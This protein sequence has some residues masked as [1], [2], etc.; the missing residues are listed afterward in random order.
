MR[1]AVAAALV[2]TMG[3]FRDKRGRLAHSSFA[4]CLYFLFS[5]IFVVCCWWTFDVVWIAGFFCCWIEVY[6]SFSFL[7]EI[8]MAG[9]F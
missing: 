2:G 6:L 4:I 5:F 7:L 9:K 3:F 1:E 8:C